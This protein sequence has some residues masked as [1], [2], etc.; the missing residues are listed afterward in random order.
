MG[1]RRRPLDAAA[2][3]ALIGETARDVREV[4]I[5]GVS[6]LLSVHEHASARTGCR[7]AA[8]VEW[9]NG[10]I[11]QAFSAEDPES[12]R[13][14]QFSAAWCDE[15]AKWRHAE[16]TF[17]M[18][19]FGLRLGTRP[20]QVITTTPRPIALL[21]RLIAD[22][23]TA[24]THAGTRGECL[25]PVRRR[26]STRSSSAIRARGSAARSSTARS[27][28]SAP[29]RC[30]RARGSRPAASRRRRPARAS[31]WR[32]IRRGVAGKDSYACGLVAAGRAWRSHLCAGRRDRGGAFARRLG[33]QGDRA[34]AQAARRIALVVEVNQGGDMVRAVIRSEG[35]ERAGD[36]GA[37][38]RAANTCAPSRS[39]RSTSRAG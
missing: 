33:Q 27:S 19:Q 39:R 22:P 31:W 34:V 2:R 36:A 26:F 14:P 7:R 16:A 11:A 25:Q 9:R 5:E 1:A 10:A 3:I 13:G 35:R 20:R 32:S 4:M 18:L 38:A 23:T 28:R 37:R 29:T 15:L 8:L 17:D 21:K 6:G 30:G 24:L 12:L